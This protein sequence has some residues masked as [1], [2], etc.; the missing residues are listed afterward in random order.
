MKKFIALFILCFSFLNAA[1]ESPKTVF[2][3]GGAG[4]MASNFVNHMFKAHPNYNIIVLDAMTYAACF[5][6]INDEVV[7]SSR[8]EFYKGSICNEKI[9]DE[10]MG[11]SDLV[12]HFAAETDVTR[13]IQD[14]KVFFETNVMGT[15]CLLRSLL[16]HR[17]KVERF[18]Q[19]KIK[20]Y[21]DLHSQFN[22]YIDIY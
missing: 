16:K 12:V 4:F 3:T 17:D 18:I 13:S 7:N 11:K 5:E 19:N 8:F 15:R 9:V 21:Y 20:K 10:I 14:D 2:V 1:E 6:N 22:Y